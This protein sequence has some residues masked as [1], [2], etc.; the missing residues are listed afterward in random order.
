MQ[1]HRSLCCVWTLIN[2]H[3][4]GAVRSVFF[5]HQAHHAHDRG[6]VGD[7]QGSP[8]D[9]NGE[10]LE[11]GVEKIKSTAPPWLRR[12]KSTPAGSSGSVPSCR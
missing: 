6:C 3:R 9:S 12:E 8:P 7:Y 4:M 10:A 5:S 2:A 1:L 11:V